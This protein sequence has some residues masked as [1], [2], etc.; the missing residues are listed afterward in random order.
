MKAALDGFRVYKIHNR[1][2]PSGDNGRMYT[3][4]LYVIGL[5]G[6]VDLF[7]AELEKDAETIKRIKGE[8]IEI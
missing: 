4:P 5:P 7:N 1:G 8:C 2:D 3:A 6:D